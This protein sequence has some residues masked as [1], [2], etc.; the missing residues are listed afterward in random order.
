MTTRPRQ[1]P[2]L[3]A[4]NLLRLLPPHLAG[5]QLQETGDAAALISWIYSVF[6]V[7]VY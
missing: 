3:A 7:H 1:A 5:E 4:R 2:R 6:C